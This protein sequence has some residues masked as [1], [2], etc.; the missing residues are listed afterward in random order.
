MNKIVTSPLHGYRENKGLS[1]NIKREEGRDREYIYA[2][3]TRTRVFI[4]SRVRVLW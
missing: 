1:S 2:T 3:C 4:T